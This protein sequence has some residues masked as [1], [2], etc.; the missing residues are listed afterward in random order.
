MI[1]EGELKSWEVCDAS[2]ANEFVKFAFERNDVLEC[3]ETVTHDLG[4]ESH[5]VMM[6]I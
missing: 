1:Y 3:N 6:S 2:S 5:T 4:E